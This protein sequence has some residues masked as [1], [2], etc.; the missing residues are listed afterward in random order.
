VSGASK[1]ASVL[2]RV[3]LGSGQDEVGSAH[4]QAR[5][6]PGRLDAHIARACRRAQ[7]GCKD[8][9]VARVGSVSGVRPAVSMIHGS[10]CDLPGGCTLSWRIRMPILAQHTCGKKRCTR[11][12]LA[13]KWD[14]EPMYVSLSRHAWYTVLGRLDGRRAVRRR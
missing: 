1:R 3:R 10:Q 5:S 12:Q 6:T 2:D 8:A 4:V 7:S 14:G 9:F 11:R 13:G